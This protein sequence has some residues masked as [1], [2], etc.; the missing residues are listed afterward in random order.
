MGLQAGH[1]GE[2]I[3]HWKGGGGNRRGGGTTLIGV[4]G[5][6]GNDGEGAGGGGGG[7]KLQRRRRGSD[8]GIEKLRYVPDDTLKPKLQN[9]CPRMKLVVSPR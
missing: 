5:G 3:M 1:K 9:P 4:G 8:Q 2:K 6:G 7:E